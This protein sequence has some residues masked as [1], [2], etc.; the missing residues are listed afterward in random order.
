MLAAIFVTSPDLDFN[1]LALI[2]ILKK[3]ILKKVSR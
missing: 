3:I 2:V 1:R